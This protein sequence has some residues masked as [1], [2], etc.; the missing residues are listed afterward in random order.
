MLNNKIKYGNKPKYINNKSDTPHPDEYPKDPRAP[1][2]IS[3]STTTPWPAT[4]AVR[5]GLF[6]PTLS[7]NGTGRNANSGD[8]CLCTFCFFFFYFCDERWIIRISSFP[9]LYLFS[10]ISCTV[11]LV[12]IIYLFFFFVQLFNIN[13]QTQTFFVILN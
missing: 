9:F 3:L 11:Q 2:L 4:T 5:F 1:C 12:L 8:F 7:E 6:H 13:P 10:L